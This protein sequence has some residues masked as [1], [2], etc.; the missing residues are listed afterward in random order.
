MPNSV[1]NEEEPPQQQEAR[2][3]CPIVRTHKRFLLRQVEFTQQYAPMYRCRMA[4]Q[5]TRALAAVKRAVAAAEADD[6][7]DDDNE[8][9]G[10]GS[11]SGG[12]GGAMVPSDELR[13]LEFRPGVPA[14][15]VGVVYKQMKL[16]PRFLDEYQRELVRIDAGDDDDEGDD[17]GGGGAG[18]TDDG[19]Q[20]SPLA[21]EA[22]QDRAASD[23]CHSQD[24]VMLEDSSGRVALHG[25]D[26]TRLCTGLVIGVYGTL[27]P[28]GV[29]Q[30]H[31]YAFASPGELAVPR[32]RLP[33]L[34]S[35]Q[36][37]HTPCYIA[38]V[39]GLDVNIPEAVAATTAGA[40]AGPTPNSFAGAGVGGVNAA[41]VPAVTAASILRQRALLELLVDFITGA[42]EDPALLATSRCITRLVIGGNSI[43]PT[44]ELRLKKKV[45]LDPSDHMRLNDD[46]TGAAAAGGAG[47]V[48]SAR[49][50]RELDGALA[51][52][53]ASVEVELM[54]GDNDMSDA[55]QPQQP[56]HPILL[57][58]AA[59]S[60]ALR[61]VS[62]PFEFTALTSTTT[63][64][65]AGSSGKAL[66]TAA[67]A[68]AGVG[69]FVTSGQ[70]VTDVALETRFPTRAAAMGMILASGC[71][72][73]T[74]PNTL[75]SYPFR[76]DDPFLFSRTPHCF[77]AC[78]Q[79]VYE[80]RYVGLAALEREAASYFTPTAATTP[81]AALKT[82][83]AVGE[84]EAGARIVC[85][86][87]FARTGTVVLVDV[88]SPTLETTRVTF[89]MRGEG[90]K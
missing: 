43:A 56:L 42:T 73:P 84:E 4:A 38:F 54:P 39:C 60:S 48:T 41:A 88:H 32:P 62:N 20:E 82:G 37:Q 78:D 11:G 66:D 30:V 52:L 75:F 1:A 2:S 79:P 27:L 40:V 61:L 81:T 53:A 35:G 64:G 46:R 45:K 65:A 31:R 14:F 44:D 47:V 21:L 9:E 5:Q 76:D 23:V 59:R 89:A 24:E 86:P 72:C 3:E 67:S 16:L 33:A 26:A 22:G 87:P 17:G 29:V 49:L 69:F 77:V 12:G 34:T 50:M 25:L 83:V 8:E 36:Q 55:F 13:V 58:T 10:Y 63:V 18:E 28:T 85:V 57:P 71:A 80:T 19:V 68:G 90:A 51:R 70:N 15:T 74:A 7:H 6:D